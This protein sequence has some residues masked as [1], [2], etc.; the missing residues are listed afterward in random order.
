MSLDT[1]L[2]PSGTGFRDH[3]DPKVVDWLGSFQANPTPG[4]FD[5][6]LMGA[7]LSKTSISH[8]AAFR[9]PDAIRAV[10]S[11]LTPYSVHHRLNLQ[12]VLRGVD[13][14]N[15][16][17]HLTDLTR[18]QDNISG[19][20]QA[21][22]SQYDAPLVLLGGDHSVTAA[23]VAGWLD[24]AKK[25]L[26]IVHFDAHHDVRNLVDGGRH[27]GTPFRT[28]LESGRIQGANLV[29]IGL[30]D[31][32]NAQPY[33]DFVRNQGATVITAREVYH[34][35]LD[36][37]LP[38]AVDLASQGTDGVYV[39]FDMDVLDQSVVP[40][41]PAPSPGGLSFWQAFEALE[42]LGR[43]P[44]VVA[45]D[46]VCAD[47]SLDFRDLTVRV[48]GHLVLAFLTGIAMRTASPVA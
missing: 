33:H 45:M 18:C 24:G 30:R 14:G 48:A 10:F 2:T 15:V 11:A 8:S 21:Y 19:A 40:G 9:L 23:A 3:L 6:A 25:S 35:G 32:V 4:S 20:V 46:L 27:N 7:P 29:Q 39:S 5:C 36:F 31:F 12:D 41:V 47:P 13:L 1:W 44:R 28:L 37:V 17:M 22:A 38:Q 34:T 16:A 42:T 43:N 26:G